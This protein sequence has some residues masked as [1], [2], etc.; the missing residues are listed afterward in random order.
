M[1]DPVKKKLSTIF[2]S[3]ML[4]LIFTILCTVYL[5]M[6]FRLTEN[7]RDHLIESIDTEFMPHYTNNDFAVL[8]KIVED[9]LFQVLN[10]KGEVVLAVQSSIGFSPDLNGSLLDA[11]SK[12]RQVFETITHNKLHY[13]VAY[14][15]LDG[16]FIGRAVHPIESRTVF[17]KNFAA[18]ML[19]ALPLLLILAYISSRYMV[20][21]SLKPISNVMKYQETFSSNVSHELKSPLTSIKGSLEVAL[22]RDRSQQEYREIVKAALNKIDDIIYLL[23]NLGLIATSKFK[24][25]DLYRERVNM[26]DLIGEIVDKYEPLIYS[27]G[28][29]LKFPEHGGASCKDVMPLVCDA[30]LMRRAIENLLDNAVKYT[31]ID[32]IIDLSC[33]NDAGTFTFTIANTCPDLS[34]DELKNL[35]EPFYR[36]K[37]VSVKNIDGRG[38]GLHVVQYIA[39][40]HGGTLT[41]Q[42]ENGTLSITVKIPHT[43]HG[44]FIQENVNQ[45]AG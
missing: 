34:K 7:V 13:L 22:R 44:N 18:L 45:V 12:G 2:I 5:F 40:S 33:R 8:S 23:N 21:Q 19:L 16:P 17:R 1:I 31:P 36:G 28:V 24:P 32:S 26:S 6:D 25:L 35:C 30:S 15:P 42:L 10:S 3:T 9:E 14:Y 43:T 20:N 37:N 38:L 4:G 39:Y 41:Y 29:T 11:A 27:K